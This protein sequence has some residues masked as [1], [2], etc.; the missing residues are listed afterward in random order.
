[1]KS[2]NYPVPTIIEYQEMYIKY[3]EENNLEN[4]SKWIKVKDLIDFVEN[5]ILVDE[6][7]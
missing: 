5:H 6:D 2:K 4:D 7:E 3:L 1:M